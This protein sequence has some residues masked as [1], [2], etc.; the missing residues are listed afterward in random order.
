GQRRGQGHQYAQH[1]HG[2][3]EDART[4][5]A[6]LPPE[7]GGGGPAALPGERTRTGRVR[8]GLRGGL[9]GHRPTL[10]SSSGYSRSARVFITITAAAKK[11]NSPCTSGRSGTLSAW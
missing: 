6:V 9:D 3:P 2:Q 11:K 4:V 8:T 10:G 1:E 5:P 7:T